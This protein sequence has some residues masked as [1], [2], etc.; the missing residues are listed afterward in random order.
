MYA[1]HNRDNKLYQIRHHFVVIHTL[2]ILKFIY[3]VVGK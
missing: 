3:N 2:P 1:K